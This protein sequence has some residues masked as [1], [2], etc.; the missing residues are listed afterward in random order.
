MALLRRFASVYL[1]IS[2]ATERNDGAL[3]VP[4]KFARTGLQTYT[5]VDGSKRVEYRSEA[6]VKASASTFEGRSVT[7][8]HPASGLVT[9]ETWENDGRGHV[10]KVRYSDGWLYGD[11]VINHGGL[12]R[13]IL[14][15]ERDELSAGY[16]A[17]YDGQAGELEGE[18]FDGAQSNINGNHVAVLAHGTARAGREAHLRLDASGSQIVPG[19][20]AQGREERD[21]MEEIEITIDGV[22]HKVKVDGPMVPLLKKRLDRATELEAE[23]VQERARADTAVL[24]RD[25]ITKAS[26]AKADAAEL[27]QV[28]A[29]AKARGFDATSH[30]VQD[31]TTKQPRAMT[32]H[33]IKVKVLLDAGHDLKEKDPSYVDGAFSFVSERPAALQSGKTVLDAVD[34]VTPKGGGTGRADGGD[35]FAPVKQAYIDANNIRTEEG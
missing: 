27:E 21:S 13:K 15:R 19:R 7:D 22:T 1:D 18:H 29:V 14:D 32:A 34:L 25:N 10:E 28:V 33:E 20:D 17:G 3:V 26:K 16:T 30:T 11:F 6:V 23:V 2:R 31:A 9:D 8:L 35:W 4:G 12:K 5:N 24:E